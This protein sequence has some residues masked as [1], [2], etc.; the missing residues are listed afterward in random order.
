MKAKLGCV[1]QGN[2]RLKPQALRSSIKVRHGDAVTEHVMNPVQLARLRRYLQLRAKEPLILAIAR[3][4]KNTMLAEA[5]GAPV[6][7]G[8]NVMNSESRQ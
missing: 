4:E 2:V 7:I 3:S 5:N 1:I 8:G 6:G